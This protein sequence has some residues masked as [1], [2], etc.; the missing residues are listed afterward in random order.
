MNTKAI[1]EVVQPFGFSVDAVT[2]DNK[3]ALTMTGVSISPRSLTTHCSGDQIAMLHNI[4]ANGCKSRYQMLMIELQMYFKSGELFQLEASAQI[5]SIRRAS[6]TE[7]EVNMILCDMSQ[8]SLR[9]IVR[10]ADE[11]AETSTE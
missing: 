4:E 1:N 8:D 3:A 7:F 2:S 5:V 6:Q 11:L 10:Y 9:H